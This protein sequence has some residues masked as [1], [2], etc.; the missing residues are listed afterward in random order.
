M[1]VPHNEETTD[2]TAL[3]TER[4]STT[5]YPYLA[6]M[7]EPALRSQFSFDQEFE[8]G[9]DLIIDALERI[10]APTQTH[11]ATP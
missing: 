11:T 1:S 3:P 4:A 9:L 2:R 10:A 8:Y 7:A 6:E 5:D